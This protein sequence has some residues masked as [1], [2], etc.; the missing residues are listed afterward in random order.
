ME[1]MKSFK[2]DIFISK[3]FLIDFSFIMSYP[4]THACFWITFNQV[5]IF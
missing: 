3:L 5:P 2:K 1:K 4:S